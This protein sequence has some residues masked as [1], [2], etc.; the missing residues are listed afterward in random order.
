MRRAFGTV[1]VLAVGVSLAGCGGKTP[2]GQVAA[3]V[4]NQEITVQE[5]QTELA[6][7]NAPDAKTRKLA[8]Q[9]ALQNIIQRKLIAEAAVK[10]GVS[11]S[12]EFAIQKER[13]EDDLL[14]RS[15]ERALVA[16]VPEPSP[17]QVKQY[18]GQHPEL[19]A[20]R[21]VYMVDQLR[22]PPTNDP[23][24]LSDL[25][26]LNTLDDIAHLLQQRN[27]RFDA[28]R[29]TLDSVD[30]GS[31]LVNQIDKMP[32]GNIFILP[33]GNALVANKIDETKVIPVPDAAAAKIAARNIK[34][35]Q[36]QESVRRM[37]GS[38]VSNPKIKIAYNKAYEPAAPAK[39][40]T[41]GGKAG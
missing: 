16:A 18:I 28:G 27:I 33:I 37:F 24:L 41:A 3:K 39:P 20:N 32:A 11:K 21:K 30:L 38:V 1:L 34:A 10:A 6:G 23:K 40:A 17:D 8:E 9:R 25:K 7:Y 19:F 26:P 15:W 13:L 35:Q 2:T 5:L 31:S 29:A 22:M 14:V 12:P 36:A 4:G